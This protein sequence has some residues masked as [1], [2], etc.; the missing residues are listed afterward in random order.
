MFCYSW[1]EPDSET[2]M[3]DPMANVY[4][5]SKASGARGII[6]MLPN[7]AWGSAYRVDLSSTAIVG[8]HTTHHD[9]LG[10][11]ISLDG[12][13]VIVKVNKAAFRDAKW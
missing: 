7:S 10:G 2:I 4:I 3:V 1:D 13:K 11:D 8:I 5:I 6:V 12:E 9:P